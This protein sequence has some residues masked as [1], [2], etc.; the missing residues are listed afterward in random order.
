MHG[1]GTRSAFDSR[2][3]RGGTLY[4]GCGMGCSADA[5]DVGSVSDPHVE[6]RACGLVER[7]EYSVVAAACRAQ[8]L[9]LAA[10]GL[11]H[12][13]GVCGEGG[14]NELDDHGRDPRGKV[15]EPPDC[16]W[17]QLG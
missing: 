11:A 4:S 3:K 10:E 1:I 7:E 14:G 2:W 8:S 15:V 17:S 13:F 9:E 16:A 5:V 6:K 12:A